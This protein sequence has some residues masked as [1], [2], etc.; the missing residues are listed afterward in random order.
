MKLLKAVTLTA[1]LSLMAGT[2]FSFVAGVDPYAAAA[3]LFACSFFPVQHGVLLMGVN[4]AGQRLIF[5]NAV[6]KLAEQGVHVSIAV[7]T[8]SYIRTEQLMAVG[9]TNIQFPLV[10]T[11]TPNLQSNTQQLIQLQD[12]FVVSEVGVFLF[13]PGSSTDTTVPLLS[14][15]NQI[16]FSTA[17]AAANAETIYHSYLTLSV[18]K[19]VIV[20]F[21]DVYR[22]RLTNQTQQTAALGAGSPEDQLSGRDD[23]FYPTEPNWVIIGS[24]SNILTLV[25]PNQFAAVQANSRIVVYMR[26]CLAQNSTSVN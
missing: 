3:G 23:V 18:N 25:M 22:S 8:Q 9:Q 24:R 21:W 16:S 11:Q 1:L 19:A 2:F 12:S 10:T 15:P 5:I 4:T 13:T 7:L 17:N 20:P 6:N 26:G 14:Y